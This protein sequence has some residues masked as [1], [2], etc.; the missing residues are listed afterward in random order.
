MNQATL[1]L[2][3]PP[4]ASHR[5]HRLRHRLGPCPPRP[6]AA[7]RTA[8]RRHAGV[9]GLDGRPRR[10][11]PPR[12]GH[13]ARDATVAAAAAAGLAPR[14]RLRGAAGDAALPGADPHRSL[15]GAAPAAGRCSVR[16]GGRAVSNASTRDAGYAAG[17]L[18]VISRQAALARDGVDVL[19]AVRRARR[20]EAAASPSPAWTRR[21][22][23]GWRRCV[24]SPRR[25]PFTKPRGCRWRC[26]RPTAC[27]CSTPCRA[28]RRW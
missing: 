4:A 1:E 11:R 26:C 5:P 12:A 23:G 3:T 7:R 18:A 6:R 9:P 15:P 20:A 19:E 10:L 8:A 24:R 27:A 14:H 13:A 21:P 22:G 28:C 16:S 25:C 2:D 17:N